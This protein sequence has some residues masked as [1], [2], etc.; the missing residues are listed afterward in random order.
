MPSSRERPACSLCISIVTYNIVADELNAL[1][2]S[3]QDACE[4][5]RDELRISIDTVVVDN[6]QEGE[7]LQQLCAPYQQ[8]LNLRYILNPDNIGYGRAHNLAIRQTTA[9]FHLVMNPDVVL[10]PDVL[11]RCIQYLLRHPEAVALSPEVRDIDSKCQYLCKRYP[12]VLDL[13]LR[14][15]APRALRKV[16]DKRLALY[17]C[18]NMVDRM[19]TAPAQ[20]ISGCFMFCRG[21]ALRQVGGFNE[22]FFLY[23]EDFAL[24][25]ELRKLGKLV[26]LPEARIVHYG[27]H[28]ARKGWTH[29][30]YFVRSAYVFFAIYGWKLR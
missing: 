26:Y 28:A 25:I 17:E 13:G 27:G 14:G 11:L 6:G 15:L 18:R 10:K 5:A 30:R 8:A 29:I 19:L 16:F 7:L 23:F 9:D 21:P 2:V 24:S 22:A 1:L 20:L 12:T 4:H 3:L